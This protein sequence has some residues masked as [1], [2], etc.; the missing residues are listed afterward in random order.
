M[1]EVIGVQLVRKSIDGLGEVI[2]RSE[3]E[4]VLDLQLIRKF[5]NWATDKVKSWFEE[6]TILDNPQPNVLEWLQ[7]SLNIL[8]PHLKDFFLDIGSFFTQGKIRVSSIIDIWME[9]Y[10]KSSKSSAVYVKYLNELAF[11]NLLEL[12]PPR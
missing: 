3:E 4:T 8:D 9:L 10:G 5:V 1:I 11:R 7:P 2:S 6:K 12:D